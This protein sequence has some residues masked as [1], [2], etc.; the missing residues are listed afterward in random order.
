VLCSH[1]LRTTLR[2]R[3]LIILTHHSH[4]F[5]L[6][7]SV[8]FSPLIEPPPTGYALP[9]VLPVPFRDASPWVEAGPVLR[10]RFLFRK[11]YKAHPRM[12]Q[13]KASRKIA[14]EAELLS[15]TRTEFP[16]CDV[17]AMSFESS[18]PEQQLQAIRDTDVLIGMHG[19]GLS[20]IPLCAFPS[21]FFVIIF[22]PE[23]FEELVKRA[24]V[25][26]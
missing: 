8:V 22:L 16:D 6:A 7:R 1:S 2:T 4:I 20:F 26:V 25:G 23:L 21:F 24:M 13:R 15:L 10:I 5:G 11:D 18:T 3:A 19:A 9:T 12:G 17:Q 14:N